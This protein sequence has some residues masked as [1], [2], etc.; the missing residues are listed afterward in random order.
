MEEIWKTI[1]E[2]NTHE[3]SNLSNV[4]HKI[5]KNNLT[6][7]LDGKGYH[8]ISILN[9]TTK[10]LI[11]RRIHRLVALAF[12]PNPNNYKMVDHIDRNKTNNVLKN[13]RWVNVKQNA[14][15]RTNKFDPRVI[16]K[17][18]NNN[19]IKIWDSCKKINEELGYF[20]SPI[21]AC[22]NGDKLTYKDCRW[23]WFTKRDKQ[24]RIK[25]TDLTNYKTI[26]KIDNYDFSNYK[27]CQEPEIKITDKFNYLMAFKRTTDKDYVSIAL[28]DKNS[29]KSIKFQLHHLIYAINNDN[30]MPKIG[31]IDHIDRNITNNKIE[32]L[33]LVTHKINT[34]RALGKKVKQIDRNTNKVIKIFDCMEDAYKVVKI[35]KNPFDSR[36]A[37]NI[38]KACRKEITAAY[39]YRWEFA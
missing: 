6:K 29:E 17:D 10:K 9:P 21:S 23:Q 1:E 27:I 18:L 12:I 26:G 36:G 14:N 25:I 11:K 28:M 37:G 16:Q 13:L 3:I 33:E 7:Q 4:R 34:T 39:G 19:T 8:K 30:K 5:L 31:V 20:G 32:N 35:S 24:T 22:C 38:G 15:N 2:I